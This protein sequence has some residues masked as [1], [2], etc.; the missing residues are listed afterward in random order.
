M[1]ANG[2]IPNVAELAMLKLRFGCSDSLLASMSK[3]LLKGPDSSEKVQRLLESFVTLIKNP[4][5]VGV[6][7]HSLI[8]W[9]HLPLSIP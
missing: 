6:K 3:L 9:I 8:D 7:V 1:A 4:L 2:L 5:G